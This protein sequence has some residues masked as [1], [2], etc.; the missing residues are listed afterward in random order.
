MLSRITVK[1]SQKPHLGDIGVGCCAILLKGTM[2]LPIEVP[3]FWHY[4]LL[5]NLDGV[6][7][8]VFLDK[9]CGSKPSQA[10]CSGTV[11]RF[12]GWWR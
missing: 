3:N 8:C 11:G 9:T 4:N 12:F 2:A 1:F 6:N 7:F 10:C 5:L